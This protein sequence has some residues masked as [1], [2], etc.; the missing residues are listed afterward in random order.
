MPQHLDF[1]LPSFLYS[2]T[3][4][5]INDWSL[6][7]SQIYN[8]LLKR[9]NLTEIN[10]NLRCWIPISKSLFWLWERT[11]DRVFHITGKCPVTKNSFGMYIYHCS[12]F[13]PFFFPFALN[14]LQGSIHSSS[15]TLK[16]DNN[17]STC[18][19][20]LFDRPGDWKPLILQDK[21]SNHHTQCASF[22]TLKFH[23]WKRVGNLLLVLLANG[24]YYLCLPVCPRGNG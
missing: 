24:H 3:G 13:F 15:V 8:F 20:S 21:K 6:A 18:Q 2:V 1:L 12:I 14:T 23:L 9:D 10:K 22:P 4:W 16:E 7:C 11:W 5:K 17:N 19:T